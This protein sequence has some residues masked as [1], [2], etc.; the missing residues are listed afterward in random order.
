MTDK[1]VTE[2]DSKTSIAADDLLHL[3]DMSGDPVTKKTVI[4][5]VVNNFNTTSAE[6]AA[7]VKKV[8]GCWRRQYGRLYGVQQCHLI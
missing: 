2:L 8:W 5:D 1:K 6:T 3:V 7:G 4:S